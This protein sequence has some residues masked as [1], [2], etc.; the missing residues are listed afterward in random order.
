GCGNHDYGGLGRRATF[1]SNLR[2]TSED[3]LLFDGGDFFGIDV[4]Y[5][6][7]K[8]DLTLQAFSYMD[9]DG[10]VL[11]EKDFVEG[12][13]Y[14]LQKV[15]K[16]KLPVVVA[17]LEDTRTGDLVF[18]PSRKVELLNGL[19]VGVIGVM[20]PGLT[21]TNQ[22]AAERLRVLEPKASVER[23]LAVLREQVDLVVVLAHMP[24]A[25]T[26]RLADNIEGVD[27]VVTGHEAR[28]MRKTRKFGNAYVLTAADRGRFMGLASGTFDVRKGM[29]EF[30]S[31]V[32]PLTPDY[33]DHEAI[34][35]L[36]QSYDMEIA[37][38]EQA[39]VSTG[40]LR[41][42]YAK[43][44]FVGADGCEPC[45]T[46]IYEQWSGT[47]HAHAFEILVE[48]EREYDRDC[49][50]CHTTGFYELGG[51]LSLVET[52]NLTGVQCE[53]CH[54]NGSTHSGAPSVK[55]PGHA[56]SVC[57][58]CHTAEQTPGFAF[59]KDWPQIAH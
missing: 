54:G 24:I 16:L 15:T 25:Q 31:E 47:R 9:Y 45:H 5:S 23:E 46:D 2:K 55:T 36:F 17:N 43:N 35:K 11:G 7:E 59:D 19:R 57:K 37:R 30:K 3:V 53:V 6:R 21:I 18:A 38:R 32:Q 8:A 33:H 48:Q 58:E 1:L 42:E 27:I 13:D 52:P 49:T 22:Q 28:P 12:L 20:A 41:G 51:F 14:L 10:I 34:V 50:P 26:K 40:V 44:P 56:R 39:R 4:N 29:V